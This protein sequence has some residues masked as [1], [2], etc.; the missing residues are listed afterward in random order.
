MN[1]HPKRPFVASNDLEGVFDGICRFELN[2][3]SAKQIREA[4]HITGNTLEEVLLAEANPIQDFLNEVLAE[5]ADGKAVGTWKDYQKLAVLAACDYDMAKVEAK[6][7]QYNNPRT[8]HI[9]KM[10]QQY[11]E[12]LSRL[13]ADNTTWTKNKILD[14]VR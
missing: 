13:P 11:R 7:R 4:L 12:I 10:V 1:L 3:T 14:A 8:S 6:I 5:D 2:L 9:P